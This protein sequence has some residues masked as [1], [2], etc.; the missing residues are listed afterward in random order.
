MALRGQGIGIVTCMDSEI[1][2]NYGSC[3]AIRKNG[4]EPEANSSRSE[5]ESVR[6][7]SLTSARKGGG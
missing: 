2:K 6:D 3:I 5:V 1:S 4:G 7:R